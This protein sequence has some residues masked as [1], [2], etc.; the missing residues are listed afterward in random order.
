MNSVEDTFKEFW[1]V[2]EEMKGGPGRPCLMYLAVE[3]LEYVHGKESILKHVV[4]TASRAKSERDCISM[5]VNDTTATKNA[6]AA[7][8]DG[9]MLFGTY[10]NTLTIQP[11]R[12][13]SAINAV[14]Y[15]YERGY[16]QVSFTPIV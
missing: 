5:V 9:H 4:T 2:V 14:S 11:L 15:D 7:A 16:P 1:R 12:P 3:K 13:S 8:S 6:V 10:A